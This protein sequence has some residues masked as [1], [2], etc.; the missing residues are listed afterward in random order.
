MKNL[1]HKMSLVLLLFICT[2]SCQKAAEVI[3]VSPMLSFDLEKNTTGVYNGPA[4]NINDSSAIAANRGKVTSSGGIS[5]AGLLANGAIKATAKFAY[6]G[7]DEY[8]I[9]FSVIVSVPPEGGHGFPVALP[10]RTS[11]IVVIFKDADGVWWNTRRTAW[12]GPNTG[13]LGDN[14]VFTIN[15]NN[16]SN[17]ASQDFYIIGLEP[18]RYIITYNAETADVDNHFHGFETIASTSSLVII[19]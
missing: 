5:E 8:D 1:F 7:A 14:P 19:N 2:V 15:K 9:R 17:F 11:H 10:G 6:L 16:A 13:G 18:G 3:W 12:G 4:L